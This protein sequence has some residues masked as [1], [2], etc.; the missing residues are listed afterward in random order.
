MSTNYS[1]FR[2]DDVTLNLTF[3]KDSS[4]VAIDITNYVIYF[5]LKRNKYDTTAALSKTVTSHTA[6]LLGQTQIALTNAETAALNGSYY[7]DMAYIT[8]I[9]GG[10][11][12]TVDAGAFTFKEDITQ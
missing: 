3:E 9:T 12:K 2:G 8:N 10:T 6:P 7:Y 1:K 4:G 5:S 11:K